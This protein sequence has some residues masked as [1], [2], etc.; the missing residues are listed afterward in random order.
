MQIRAL[1]TAGA[2]LAG[3]ITPITMA[4]SARADTIS[5]ICLSAVG[6]GA[7]FDGPAGSKSQLQI[8]FGTA[9]YEDQVGTVSNQFNNDALNNDYRGAPIYE[10]FNDSAHDRCIRVN[11]NAPDTP[12]LGSPGAACEFVYSNLDRLVSIGSS[13]DNGGTSP[14]YLETRSTAKGSY[15]ITDTV[16]N[17]RYTKWIT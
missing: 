11:A 1:L 13:N 16:I 7:C 14:W 2:L 4:Q 17:G 15:I 9:Y 8:D 3:I 6:T 12:V 10:F 5:Y